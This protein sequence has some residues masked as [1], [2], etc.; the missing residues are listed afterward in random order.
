MSSD[1][2]SLNLQDDDADFSVPI[3]QGPPIDEPPRTQPPPA[4]QQT[5]AERHS[6]TTSFQP[7]NYL[8][9]KQN[10]TG[11]VMMD[12]TPI[13]ELML[14]GE[15][16]SGILEPPMMQNQLTGPRVQSLQMQAAP[17]TQMG[18]GFQPPQQEVKPQ[19]KN[20]LNLTD[21]QMLA[22]LVAGA[23]ALAVSKPVQDKLATSIPKFL[24]E[25]GGRSA[26]GL[27]ATGS[28]AAIAFYFAKGQFV[29][30]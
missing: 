23:C 12:S 28:V 27:L 30:A 3:T 1:I 15:D 9:Q 11:D 17:Q 24:N 6:G 8:S 16:A 7:N 29:K 5:H 22:V 10:N 19:P 14:N 4:M 2:A 20:P 21:D 18:S 25:Q 13:N 26:V